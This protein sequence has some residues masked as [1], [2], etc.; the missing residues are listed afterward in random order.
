MPSK[1]IKFTIALAM[2][3][4]L[5][6]G[7]V[8]TAAAQASTPPGPLP[9][10]QDE[11]ALDTIEG[12]YTHFQEVLAAATHHIESYAATIDP[13][14]YRQRLLDAAAA[15]EEALEASDPLELIK[16]QSQKL[17]DIIDEVTGKVALID[18]MSSFD[19]VL[20]TA[21]RALADAKAA[22]VDIT[23]LAST[24]AEAKARAA[25]ATD[26][27]GVLAEIDVVNAA[28]TAVASK[29]LAAAKGAL[30]HASS[31]WQNAVK[32][33]KGKVSVSAWS[34]KVTA[35][36][37]L[38]AASTDPAVVQAQTKVVEAA[39]KAALASVKLHDVKAAFTKA[40]AEWKKVEK[41]AKG[42]VTVSAEVKRLTAAL[43]AVKKSSDPA[44]VAKYTTALRTDI[45][46][47][48]ARVDMHGAKTRYAAAAKAAKKLTSIA[49]GKIQ[50][51]GHKNALAGAYKRA[52]A[53]KTAAQLDKETKRVQ[54]LTRTLKGYV[55]QYDRSYAKKPAWF[56][57][58]RKRLD[59]VGGK[60][61]P[62]VIFDG[63]CGKK[64]AVACSHPDP[65]TGKAG[66][67]SIAKGVTKWSPKMRDWMASHEL[68]HQKQFAVWGKMAASPI[69]KKSFRQ[70]YE[71]VANCMAEV[72]GY[73][74]PSRA[75]S[76]KTSAEKRFVK[77]LW[78]GTV[79]TR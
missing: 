43:A 32:A 53:T 76:C 16:A 28:V 77:A 66:R 14:P 38:A 27:D 11:V 12:A 25:A 26:V 41:A 29:Y 34:V 10:T 24:I 1:K 17:Q 60:D 6:V 71:R 62:L 46:K 44:Q 36:Q 23:A 57:D 22:K 75:T 78:R 74:Y 19:K 45:S 15:A 2:T 47:V 58:I 59:K 13:G 4:G 72:A 9:L 52:A 79:L 5:I 65:Y 3:S 20:A 35:A 70:N 51:P 56:K 64:V 68:A 30:S 50:F 31:A 67:I 48:K 55:T 40:V 8:P 7:V 42:K 21:E 39:T 73:K 33:A 37:K 61:T 49:T 63:K 18:V 69:Y 54:Q